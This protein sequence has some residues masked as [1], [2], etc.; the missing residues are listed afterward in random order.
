MAATYRGVLPTEISC[1][2]MA[3]VPTVRELER[4][5]GGE[6]REPGAPRDFRIAYAVLVRRISIRITWLLLHTRLSANGVTLLGIGIGHRGR[7]DAGLER[8][9]AARRRGCS[10]SSSPSSSTTRTARSRATAHTSAGR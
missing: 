3:S 10:C 2:G 9:L 5:C 7:A 8:V 6:G 4:I 1:R